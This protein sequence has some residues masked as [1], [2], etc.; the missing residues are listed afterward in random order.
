MC[1]TPRGV[2]VAGA[3]IATASVAD[4]EVVAT[5]TATAV[6]LA[7]A[8]AADAAVDA[9]VDSSDAAIDDAAVTAQY[10]RAVI[11]FLPSQP[12]APAPAVSLGALEVCTSKNRPETIVFSTLANSSFSCF[13]LQTCRRPLPDSGVVPTKLYPH[14]ASVQVCV[15]GSFLPLSR[16]RR[17][18]LPRWHHNVACILRC[19]AGVCVAIHFICVSKPPHSVSGTLSV[20]HLRWLGRYALTPPS[21]IADYVC[22]CHA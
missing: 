12:A 16:R 17:A 5:A 21:A 8:S 22:S 18:L 15:C 6:I 3:A 7:T 1:E 9:V 2:T 20:R 11:L 4:A 19:D 14:N 10:E 13:L